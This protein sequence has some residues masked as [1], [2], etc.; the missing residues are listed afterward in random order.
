MKSI[1][2]YGHESTA[3]AAFELLD[4][5]LRSHQVNDVALTLT[6]HVDQ[7]IGVGLRRAGGE[8]WYCGPR[9]QPPGGGWSP[10]SADRYLV[11]ACPAT[12]A[13]QVTGAFTEFI[14]R[15]RGVTP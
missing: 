11:A 14:A 1:I 8:L 10:L 13:H 6:V 5:M 15:H 9:L 4:A 2:L 3:Q 12:L 7:A